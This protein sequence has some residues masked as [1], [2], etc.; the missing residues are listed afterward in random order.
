M[1]ID[2]LGMV[3]ESAVMGKENSTDGDTLLDP[4]VRMEYQLFNWITHRKPNFVHTFA[5]EQHGAT[6]PRWQESYTYSNGTGAIALVKAQA[7]PGPAL[8]ANPD[9]TVAEV[10]ADPQAGGRRDR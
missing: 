7:H 1:N 4:T 3:T 2:A 5:R 8:I 10:H 6:N 9:G